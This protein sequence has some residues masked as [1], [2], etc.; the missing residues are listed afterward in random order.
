MLRRW[1]RRLL[2]A[3][4]PAV[5]VCLPEKLSR[6][7]ERGHLIARSETS[8]CVPRQQLHQ[9]RGKH[10]ITLANQQATASELR[11]LAGPPC[12]LSTTV[13]ALLQLELEGLASFEDLH[14]PLFLL[15][16]CRVELVASTLQRLLA[17]TRLVA[18]RLLLSFKLLLPLPL[19]CVA[20]MHVCKRDGDRGRH[21]ERCGRFQRKSKSHDAVPLAGALL[22]KEGP[23][24]ELP[25]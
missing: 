3:A 9:P 7:R 19:H 24:G 6:A 25:L 16:V 22:Q 14:V 4:K 23:Q 17:A 10:I 13:D 2:R 5:I 18:L 11:L 8:T 1:L 21:R 20:A 12:K 15:R